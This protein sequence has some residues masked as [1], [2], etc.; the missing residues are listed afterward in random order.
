MSK[1]TNFIN[2]AITL[3]LTVALVFVAAYIANL[4]FTVSNVFSVIPWFL[5]GAVAAGVINAFAHELGHYF[6]GKKNGFAFISM[7]VW[8]FKWSKVGGKTS[9]SFVMLGEASGITEMV[10]VA[11]G[12]LAKRFKKMTLGG[13]IAST[14]LTVLSIIPFAVVDFIGSMPLFSV[15][16]MFLPVSAYYLFGNALPISTDGVRNDGGVICGINK[17]DDTSKTTVNLLAIQ[18]ELYAGKTPSQVDEAL[19]FDLSQL[20]E[21]DYYFV[22]ITNARYNY[23]LDKEDYENAIKC[24]DRL[25]GIIDNLPKPIRPFI[26]VDALFNACTCDFNQDE[27]DDLMYELDKYLNK[28]NDATSVRVKMAYLAFI[29]EETENIGMFYEKGLKEADKHP[30]KG[31]GLYERKLLTELMAKVPMPIEDGEDSGDEQ[32]IAE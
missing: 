5:I 6:A 11:E 25:M 13:I 32:P 31:Y 29:R 16:S 9:F 10:N 21:D 30:I 15:F 14:V 24:T 28:T 1:R 20:P 7:T 17:N 4:K 19:Y 18:G 3:C 22:A 27:A 26:K 12:N 23:Y 8:F 2:N